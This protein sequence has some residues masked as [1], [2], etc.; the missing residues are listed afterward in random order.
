M[1]GTD[2]VHVPYR[3][4]GPAVSDLLGGQVDMMFD[5]IASARPHVQAGKLVALGVTTPK[6]SQAMADVRTVAEAGVPG[7]DLTPWF[8]VLMPASTPKQVVHAMNAALLEAMRQ[9]EVK[10]RFFVLGAEP[11]GGTPEQFVAVVATDSAKWENLIRERKIRA[12]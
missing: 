4:S 3:G 5:S 9:T 12:D 8:G 7:Y 10:A 2:I 11:I 6:R 1:T